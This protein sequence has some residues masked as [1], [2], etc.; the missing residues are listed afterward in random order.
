MNS[1]FYDILSL[2]V[3]VLIVVVIAF[4]MNPG[5][6]TDTFGE[7]TGTAEIEGPGI[8][9]V[10]AIVMNESQYS[11]YQ[12]SIFT[13]EDQMWLLASRIS[14]AMDY[15]QPETRNFAARYI[16]EENSGEFTIAQAS[17]IWDG[18]TGEWVY[19]NDEAGIWDVSPAS[20]T[21]NTGLTGDSNDFAIFIA[22]LIKSV[23]GQAR[24]K[25]AQS[26]QAGEHTYAELYLGNSDDFNTKLMNSEAL[27]ALKSQY[28]YAF[29]N[30]P[31]GLNVFKYE[32]GSI[33]SGDSCWNYVKPFKLILN[34]PEKYGEMCYE[35]PKLIEYLL[36][37]PDTNII[38]FQIMYLKFRYSG[39]SIYSPGVFTLRDIS[40]SSEFEK[41]GD[42]TY[43]LKFDRLGRYPGDDYYTDT[44]YAK[45]FYSDSSWDDIRFDTLYG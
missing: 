21:I 23:G 1:R 9:E 19:Q 4:V 24:I 13:K 3:A 30:D 39:Y 38:D 5:L 42:K 18:V 35:Y 11:S 44:G 2:I 28:F 33:C 27:S 20:R 14:G 8:S 40:Y 37:F 7:Q 17:D 12:K 34:E 25:V 10:P 22:S 6:F 16:P 32:S 43:W 26:P 29:A 45:V 15:Y 41:N 36:L 31:S